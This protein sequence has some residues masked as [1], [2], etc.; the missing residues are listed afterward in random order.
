MQDADLHPTLREILGQPGNPDAI[1]VERQDP[2]GARAEF[3][4]DIAAV[5]G[6]APELAAVRDL[7]LA[8]AAG[9]L[10]ARLYLP[11]D[12]PAPD[13]PLLVYFHG[14]GNIRGNI[15]THDSTVRVLAQAAGCPAISC[16]YRLAPEHPYPAAVDDAQAALSDIVAR[17][18]GLGLGSGPLV[19]AGDSAGGN[20][21]AALSLRLR[22]AGGPAVAAQLLI[23]PVIDHL[24]ETP[25]RAA[26]SDGYM[27]NSMPF[28]TACYL[29]DPA[30]RAE[31]CASPGRAGDLS[32]L[33]PAVVLTAGFDP[34]RD[35]ALA[36][37]DGLEAAGVPVTRLHYPDMIHGFTL[38]RGLLP[39]ADAALADCARAVLGLLAR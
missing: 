38:L 24:A 29:P 39:E 3:D 31:P 9:D 37:A 36:Y 18:D 17:R 11:V 34:L 23:Y 27:L 28:Y 12:P 8:G 22:A 4:A 7:T 33:P 16:S 13:A 19:V 25:S 21:A 20:L 1:P 2:V 5:D 10:A 26:F 35:E 6:P 30:R 15:G 14:G 32:G